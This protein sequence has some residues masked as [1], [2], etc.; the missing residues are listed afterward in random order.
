MC[1]QTTGFLGLLKYQHN[2]N[3]V[4]SVVSIN[5]TLVANISETLIRQSNN[6]VIQTTNIQNITM[7]AGEVD[8][9]NLS[10][11]QSIDAAY[12]INIELSQEDVEE[13]RDTVDRVIDETIRLDSSNLQGMLSDFPTDQSIK[14]EITN[15]MRDITYNTFTRDTVQSVL[16]STNNYQNMNVTY[17]K[18]TSE[19]CSWDQ[20]I[21][22]KMSVQQLMNVVLDRLVESEHSDRVFNIIAQEIISQT[23]GPIEAIGQKKGNKKGPLAA[24]IIGIALIGIIGGIIAMVIR[25]A[26]N[27]P[28]V[29]TEEPTTVVEETVRVSQPAPNVIDEL[30]AE[31]RSNAI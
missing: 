24:A 2:C 23:N 5:D 14:T 12:G 31:S 6:L 20:S 26:S 1:T 22:L 27:R 13:L 17:G 30:L 7:V 25:S 15:I 11:S 16:A 28:S 10:L 21:V 19:N 8:C 4:N 9:T 18:L 3:I 29:S